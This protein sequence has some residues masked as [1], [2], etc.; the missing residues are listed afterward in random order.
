MLRSIG[1][2]ARGLRDRPLGRV[3]VLAV[4]LLAAFLV[5][6]SC[7]ATRTKISQDQAIEIAKSSISYTPNH[8]LVRLIKRGLHSQAFWAVSLS[9]KQP[10]G[11]LTNVTVVV[12]HGDTGQVVE[13][14]HSD[15]G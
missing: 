8:V 15:T 12:I 3:L 7:G 4:I 9:Q 11:R 5:S 6:K 2:G 13:K 1:A 14:R 10:D